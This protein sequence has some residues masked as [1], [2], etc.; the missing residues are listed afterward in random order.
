M[1]ILALGDVVGGAA[2]LYLKQKLPSFLSSE[3]I[4][5]VVANGEN[6][7]DIHGLS[8][9]DARALWALGVDVITLGNHAFSRRDLYDLLDN[10]PRIVR[11][12]NYP[13][14]AAGAGY[15]IRVA[16][17]YRILVMNV[18]GNVYLSTLDNPFDA[19]EKILARESG[20][21][22]FALLDVHAE[23]TSEKLAFPYL[24]DGRIAAIFGTH[25]HVPTA[26]ERVFPAGTG[27]ITDLG[28]TGPTDGILGTR[29]DLVIEKFR[30]QM[31]TRFL[32]AEG[33]VR[34]MGA[35]FDVDETTGKT[36]AVSRVTF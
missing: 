34:A 11:P 27:Y 21:Y 16:E 8:A 10:D 3:K 29:A 31:P 23:A 1:K 17:G 22:D 6:A 9:D 32:V 28:M 36:V 25:T 15:T 35:V 18:M 2:L 33:A 30:T 5:F 20:H 7:T 26:D 13:A 12:A 4:S 14:K 24:F 19:V